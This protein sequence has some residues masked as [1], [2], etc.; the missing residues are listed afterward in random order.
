[1][2]SK[3]GDG[4][5]T[6]CGAFS[7]TRSAAAFAEV[8]F[9]LIAP[10]FGFV[11]PL[12]PG[13]ILWI[14]MLTHGLP[15]VAMGAEPAAPDVLRRAADRAGDAGAGPAAAAPDRRDRRD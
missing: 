4:S 14:N 7:G 5:T 15:G 8:V 6:T 13:Q 2:P 3:R 12:L 9:V 1:M 10:F 11:V